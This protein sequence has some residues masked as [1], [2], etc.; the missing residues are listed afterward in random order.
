MMLRKNILKPLREEIAKQRQRLL[1]D[2]QRR[3][4]EDKQLAN[5]NKQGIYHGR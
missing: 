3:E 2:A 5:Q 4:Q 1:A